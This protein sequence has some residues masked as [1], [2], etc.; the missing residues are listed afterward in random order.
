ME[1]KPCRS[2]VILGS[3][4]VYQR[5]EVHFQETIEIKTLF[6]LIIASVHDRLAISYDNKA[7]MSLPFDV[8]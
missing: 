5:Q 7:F 1:R 8:F 2:R 4:I 6:K 3:I